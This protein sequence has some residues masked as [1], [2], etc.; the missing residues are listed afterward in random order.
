MIGTARSKAFRTR[1][2]RLQ[3]AAN[4]IKSGIDALIV[5]GGDGSLTGAD[6]LRQEWSGLVK[7]LSETGQITSE[8]A[9]SVQAHLT[10]VG[11]VGS[12]DNDMCM[13]GNFN[14]ESQY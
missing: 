7:E 4:M 6:I 11:M 14:F 5:I 9:N 3:A 1:E 10:I 8:Q 12:I 13:T 2:G